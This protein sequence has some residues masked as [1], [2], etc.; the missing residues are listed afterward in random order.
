M[1]VLEILTEE[2]NGKS[3]VKARVAIR[4]DKSS[5]W[6]LATVTK[7]HSKYDSV[8]VEYDDVNLEVEGFS[9]EFKA[10]YFANPSPEDAKYYLLLKPQTEK[11]TK[12]FS[13]VEIAK[14]TVNGKKPPKAD[15]KAPAALPADEKYEVSKSMWAQLKKF[16]SLGNRIA[17]DDKVIYKGV[18]DRS[19][20]QDN[21][22]AAIKELYDASWPEAKKKI[23]VGDFSKLEVFEFRNKA[24]VKCMTYN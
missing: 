13:D 9:I 23:E 19:K 16:A 15:K 21:A 22:Q 6:Y 20:L 7:Y 12:G 10:K 8:E 11:S 18:G 1:K 3:L 17:I 5:K 2:T 24:W 4:L 14:F